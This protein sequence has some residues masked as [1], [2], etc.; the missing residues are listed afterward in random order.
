MELLHNRII[1]KI[2]V[3]A[4]AQHGP[5]PRHAKKPFLTVFLLHVSPALSKL[6]SATLPVSPL[7]RRST[8]TTWLSVP[9]DRDADILSLE[10]MKRTVKQDQVGHENRTREASGGK[11]V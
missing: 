1:Q 4:G 2:V 6:A 7:G 10:R 3:K 8:R 5:D 11:R 9:P